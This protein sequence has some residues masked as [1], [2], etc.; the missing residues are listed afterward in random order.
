MPILVARPTDGWPAA[1]VG[2]LGELVP[3]GTRRRGHTR[4]ADTAAEVAGETVPHTTKGST[5]ADAVAPVARVGKHSDEAALELVVPR[6][7]AAEVI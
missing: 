5:P 1:D 3:G 2:K 7:T 6:G 4:D